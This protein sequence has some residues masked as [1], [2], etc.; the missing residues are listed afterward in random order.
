MRIVD[1]RVAQVAIQK[2]KAEVLSSEQRA[3]THIQR[4]PMD[5][6]TWVA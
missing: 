5:L 3:L 2:D 6:W 4:I 1:R